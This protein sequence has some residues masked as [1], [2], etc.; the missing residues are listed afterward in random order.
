MSE[1]TKKVLD[2]QKTT[3]EEWV[4]YLKEAHKD[5]PG[6]TPDSF[7]NFVNAEGLNSYRVLTNVLI[8]LP[9]KLSVLDLACGDANLSTYIDRLP[10]KELNILGLDMSV[11]EL[12]LA[13]RRKFKNRFRIKNEMAD[14][15]SE[16]DSS[17]DA[18]LCHMAF[19]L[20]NPIEP[21]VNEI[22]RLLKPGGIFAAII[23]S[24]PNPNDPLSI[25]RKTF[26]TFILENFPKFISPVTGDNR[27]YSDEKIHEI[28]PPA[29]FDQVELRRFKTSAE[30]TLDQYW[31]TYK[32]YYFVSALPE[33]EKMNFKNQLESEVKK[34]LNSNGKTV[35]ESAQTMIFCKRSL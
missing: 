13:E 14:K 23:G 6:M 9:D 3:P 29:K 1:F 2:G 25:F 27:V 16:P 34:S 32:D 22:H 28:F 20:M 35:V 4:Q 18:V 31:P 11:H 24:M 10:N 7:D 17:F 12:A 19:M 21:V 5:A 33:K 15:I 8:P 26:R 30:I